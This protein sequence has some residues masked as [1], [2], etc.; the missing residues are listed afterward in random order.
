M[1]YYPVETALQVFCDEHMALSASQT[2]H[3]RQL[4]MGVLLAGSSQLSRIAR[5]LKQETQQDSRVQWIRR[6]LDADYLS[7][8]YVYAPVIQ[9]LLQGEAGQRLHLIMDRSNL[10]PE[11]VDVLSVCLSYH[12]R[13]LPLVW[14]T[15]P[16]GMSDSQRQIQLLASC[17]PLLPLESRVVLH[18]DNEFGSVRMM[19]DVRQWQWDFVLGQSSKNCYRLAPTGSWQALASLPVSSSR[20]IYLNHIE[21]TKEYA[22][23]PLNLF[24]FY[25]PTFNGRKHKHDITYCATSLPITP[26]LRRIGHRRW[27]IEC[28]F[29]DL[30]S[31]GWQLHLSALTDDK[32]REGLLCALSL[33]YLWATSLGRWLCKSARRSLIDAHP[34]RHLSLFRL[35]WDWLVHHYHMDLPCPVISTLYP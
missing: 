12:K 5:W 13:A 15:M 24:A 1:K 31:A 33:T 3:V 25:Q 22:F 8:A 32:R 29:K 14:Q 27:G 28:H 30:K 19:Q 4:C 35:G 17:R 20:S 6:L 2:R 18:G 23:G 10:V 16:H 26:A 7:Q 11:E 21:L 34:S 9:R